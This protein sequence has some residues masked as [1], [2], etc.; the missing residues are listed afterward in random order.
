M[1]D[2]IAVLSI[3]ALSAATAVGLVRMMRPRPGAAMV[4]TTCGHAGP[5]RVETRG[6][7]LVEL[8][9]WLA[10]LVPGLVYSLWRLSTRRLVCAECGS[11]ALVPTTSPVGRR[12]L[13]VQEREPG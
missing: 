8:L 2:L 11:A 3:F 9:A 6:S 4:C 12:I 7:F 1:Q 5:S 10:F 13:R